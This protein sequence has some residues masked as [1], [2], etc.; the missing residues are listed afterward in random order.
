VPIHENESACGEYRQ[1]AG[2]ASAASPPPWSIDELEACFVVIDNAGQKLA[3]AYF[4]EEPG[5][6]ISGQ[7]AKTS[8]AD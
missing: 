7:A 1:R 2:A 4:E 8:M 5:Q 6:A 3:Y